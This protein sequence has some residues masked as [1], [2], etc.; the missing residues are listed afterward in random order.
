MV[1]K[2]WREKVLKSNSI[3][4]GLV[5]EGIKWILGIKFV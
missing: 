3:N 5:L 1:S 4:F 2:L